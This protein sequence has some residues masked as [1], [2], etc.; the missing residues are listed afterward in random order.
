M[1]AVVTLDEVNQ[2]L[3][4]EKLTLATF[5]EVA[6]LETTAQFVVIGTL[7]SRYD[8]TGWTTVDGTPKLVRTVIAMRVAAW[9]Y[10]RQYSEEAVVAGSYGNWLLMQA[11]VLLDQLV[12]GTMELADELTIGTRP[13][14]GAVEETDPTF[15]MGQVF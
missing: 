7:S 4:Q 12:D 10:N 14:Q 11:A 6:E 3:P 2:F 9:A 1:A 13:G 15:L 5:T 8:T